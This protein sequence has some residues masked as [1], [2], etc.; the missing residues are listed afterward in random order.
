M[1]CWAAHLEQQAQQEAQPVAFTPR[2][3]DKHCV[4]ERLPLQHSLV[5]GTGKQE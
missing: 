5:W 1:V 3:D 4:P 2:H